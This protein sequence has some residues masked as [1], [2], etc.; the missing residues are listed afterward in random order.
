LLV[1][2]PSFRSDVTGEVELIEEVARL[3]GYDAFSSEIRPFRPGTVPDAPM[4]TS[5]RRVREHLI[6]AGLYEARPMPFVRE[7]SAVNRVRNPLAEDEAFLRSRI[8][9]SLAGR[10]EHNWS[11]MQRDVRLFEIGTVF[12]EERDP[13][14]GAP[15]ERVHA[16]AILTGSRR[17]PHFT[18]PHPPRFDEWDAKGLG[19]SLALAAYPGAAVRCVPSVGDVLWTVA[20]DDKAV[21]SVSRIALDAPAWA[22]PV[23]GIEI[24]LDSLPA[25]SHAPSRYRPIPV[26]PAIEVDLALLVPD[27]VTAAQVA[28]AIRGAAGE[29]LESLDLFD[30]FRGPG[31]AEG[32]RSLAWRLTFRHAERTL[33]DREIQG[34]TAKILSTLEAA[35]GIRQRTS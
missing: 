16:A 19:E 6:A 32:T 7:G 35:L 14:S 1:T 10:V 26:M 24:D 18:E 13:V 23:F 5:A 2:V 15:R 4:E 22:A 21:G 33:R 20:A 3:H 28:E 9:D 8:L 11:H 17:P 30:E 34:R 12:T 27:S 25:G 31:V 29:L